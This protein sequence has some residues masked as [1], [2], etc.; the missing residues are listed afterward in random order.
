[1]LDALET[2]GLLAE[3]GTMGR[4]ATRMRVT[5]SAVSKRVAVLEHALSA[6]LIEREGRRVRLTPEA[7]ALVG[8]AQPLLAEL[9]SAL[10]GEQHLSHGRLVLGVAESILSSWGPAVLAETQRAH[11]D[12]ELALHTHRSPV[13]LD[14]V[15]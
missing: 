13:A 2:L 11:P 14:G 1:M 4:V 3:L 9:R 6:K 5:Q 7:L 15:Q 8:R 10:A 12:V